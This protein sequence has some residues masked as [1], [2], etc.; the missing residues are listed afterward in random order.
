MNFSKIL[1]ETWAISCK[2]LTF[3]WNSVK[4][5]NTTDFPS[6]IFIK[7]V[8][9]HRKT[10][11]FCFS[12][13]H[14]P[15]RGYSHFTAY[16]VQRRHCSS[17]LGY[18]VKNPLQKVYF[19]IVLFLVNPSPA[20]TTSTKCCYS[21]RYFNNQRAKGISMTPAPGAITFHF[22]ALSKVVVIWCVPHN[23]SQWIDG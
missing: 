23:H 3:P 12:H 16:F 4:I 13:I 11:E 8:H 20:S 22:S 2:I 19:S 7:N 15:S 21:C 9:S 18:S 10:K 17:F 14:H 5:E 1:I 6:P